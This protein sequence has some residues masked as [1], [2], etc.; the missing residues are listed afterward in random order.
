MLGVRIL[1]V[2]GE[3]DDEMV[4]ESEMVFLATIVRV[5]THPTEFAIDF[6]INSKTQNRK[7][8]L[9]F[10]LRMFEIFY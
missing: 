7:K 10:F 2:D 1:T 6:E 8:Q 9:P 5:K 3:N 4:N